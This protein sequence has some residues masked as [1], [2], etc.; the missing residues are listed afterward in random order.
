MCSEM[1]VEKS[2]AMKLG[3]LI[4]DVCAGDRNLLFKIIDETGAVRPHVAIFVGNDHCKEL[5]G[6]DATVGPADKVSIFPA[7][8]GG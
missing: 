4:R 2:A 8:S 6:L 3:D 7:L 1:T 5:G